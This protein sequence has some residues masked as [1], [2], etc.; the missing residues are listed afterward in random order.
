MWHPWMSQSSWYWWQYWQE[1]QFCPY[2]LLIESDLHQV[3]SHHA[4]VMLLLVNKYHYKIYMF[5][6]IKISKYF[7][8]FV[9]DNNVTMISNIGE[10][11][12]RNLLLCKMLFSDKLKL[13]SVAGSSYPCL[14]QKLAL[15]R[16]DISAA[17]LWSQVTMEDGRKELG[18]IDRKRN[19]SF[20]ISTRA[21]FTFPSNI[22]F[23]NFGEQ[24]NQ[25]L[26]T[27][28]TNNSGNS[29]LQWLVFFFPARKSF[30]QMCFY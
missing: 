8:T 26:L 14:V 12:G 24:W 16:T 22:P 20:Q 10:I 3:W 4:K 11:F 25:H 17:L 21:A 5:C 29:A 13:N 27:V 28:E 15:P 30:R 7:V 23:S 9:Y 19:K 1:R 2:T 6:K 18:G